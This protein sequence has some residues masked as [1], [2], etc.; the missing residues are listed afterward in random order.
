MYASTSSVTTRSK[1]PYCTRLV[2]GPLH[3]CNV[4]NN[5][6]EQS[7][8]SNAM[9]REKQISNKC[10]VQVE[11]LQHTKWEQNQVHLSLSLSPPPPR[12]WRFGPYSGHGLPNFLP[13]ILSISRHRLPISY[14][15]QGHCI[16]LHVVFP[17][18]TWPSYWP[19][20]SE[21]SFYTILLGCDSLPSLQRD[22]PNNQVPLTINYTK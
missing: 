8:V 11:H 9:L 15:E 14:M 10:A 3:I 19:F 17:P 16:L 12:P 22:Q 6:Q 7:I 1:Q 18:V 4:Y 13:P 2:A 20:S 5:N 21:A